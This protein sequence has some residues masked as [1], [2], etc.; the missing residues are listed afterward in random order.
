MPGLNLTGGEV[1]QIPAFRVDVEHDRAFVRV[2]P[3]GELDLATVGQV[4]AEIDRLSGAGFALV[5]LDLRRTTFVDSTGVHLVLDAQ[6]AS[7]R[8][9][10]DFGVI[11]G[12]P[13]VQRTFEIAGMLPHVR[14]HMVTVPASADL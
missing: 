1:P 6:A 4:A 10:W 11:A 3:V 13:Q 9:G 2:I 14:L 5:V 8:D 12:P 7:S